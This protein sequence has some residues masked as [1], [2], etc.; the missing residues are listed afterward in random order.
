MLRIL[1][2]RLEPQAEE[3]IKEEQAVSEQEGAQQEHNRANIFNLRILCEKCLQHQQNRYHIFVDFKKAF[4]AVWHAALWAA[5]RLYNINANMIRTIE[6]LYDKATSAVCYDNNIGEWLEQQ[7]E[8]ATDVCSPPLSS[9][10]SYR[11]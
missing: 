1:L 11:E 4:D 8:Y 6:C 3:I 5:M 10:S 2:N 9:T 7:L